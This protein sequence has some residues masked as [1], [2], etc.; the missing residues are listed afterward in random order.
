MSSN[1]AGPCPVCGEVPARG[2]YVSMGCEYARCSSISCALFM[3]SIELE[4][5]RTLQSHRTMAIAGEELRVGTTYHRSAPWEVQRAIEKF[6][7]TRRQ[8]GRGEG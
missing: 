6:D 1:D 5:W 8:C 4:A 3:A 7:A 2:V